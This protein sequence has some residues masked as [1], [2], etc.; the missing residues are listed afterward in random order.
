MSGS[1]GGGVGR[2]LKV[3]TLDVSEYTFVEGCHNPVILKDT[4]DGLKD[5]DVIKFAKGVKDIVIGTP[6]GDPWLLGRVENISRHLSSNLITKHWAC[7]V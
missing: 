4:A 3:V 5:A 7:S 2:G 6:Y 1:G